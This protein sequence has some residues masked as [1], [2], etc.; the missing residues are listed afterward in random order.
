MRTTSLF[1]AFLKRLTAKRL[2][3][4]T[5]AGEIPNYLD[6]FFA[7][8]RYSASVCPGSGIM[9]ITPTNEDPQRLFE[10]IKE[11][12]LSNRITADDFRASAGQCLKWAHYLAPFIER[13]TRIKCWP[14]LGQ[15]W[16]GDRKVWGPTWRELTTMVSNGIH[17]EDIAASGASGI[18]LHAWLTLATGEIVDPTFASTLAVI[19]GGGYANL[20]GMVAYGPEEQVFNGHRYY[21]MLAGSAAIEALQARSSLP[22]LTTAREGLG[23]YSFVLVPR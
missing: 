1:N 9:A 12:I 20:L 19:Q 13:E 6:A 18:N 17:P 7:C 23:D 11:V 14:T 21:P 4:P 22:L 8:A 10:P 5:K 16:K 15:L 2:V 3:D